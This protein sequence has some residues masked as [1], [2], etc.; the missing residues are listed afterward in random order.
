MT[1]HANIADDYL[2]YP[3]GAGSAT[4]GQFLVANGDGTTSWRVLVLS[5]ISD[6]SQ[7]A[8]V[9]TISDTSTATTEDVGDKVNE[10]INALI[11]AGLMA[12]S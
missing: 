2:H 11:T 4:S 3:K 12:S 1:E 5:D 9:A 7:I 8:N 6:I 10:L